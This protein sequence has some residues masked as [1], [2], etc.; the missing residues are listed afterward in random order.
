[1]QTDEEWFAAQGPKQENGRRRLHALKAQMLEYRNRRIK[2]SL[3]D[4]CLASW[5]ALL[6]SAFFECAKCEGR[7][8][9]VAEGEALI[10]AIEAELVRDGLV[11]HAITKGERSTTVLL[12]DQITYI[13]ALISAYELTGSEGYLNKATEL[14]ERVLARFQA[15]SGVLLQTRL[16]ES[17]E[18]FGHKCEV[19]D[20]VIPAANSIA[21][22]AL[23]RLS[24]LT[25]NEEYRQRAVSMIAA[26]L[27]HLDFAGSYS[28][29]L[30]CM[31]LLLS[32]STEVV[33]SGPEALDFLHRWLEDY[34]PAV[35]IAAS[36]SESELPL[37]KG[38]YNSR[39]AAY[40]C[41]NK[42]CT[43][44]VFRVE[45]VRVTW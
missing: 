26:V 25:Q 9:L 30:Q 42:T 6:A 28:N 5:N 7:H 12:D 22:K 23:L 21:C 41:R 11:A 32:P 24:A 18:V 27:P 16:A 10:Q 19:Q 1:M 44:P 14:M 13:D 39:T 17:W 40:V 38:R 36:T 3:D 15:R 34:N 45:D 8:S 4:K 20:N 33:V 35:T 43:P 2:P 29:W 31:L 37:L